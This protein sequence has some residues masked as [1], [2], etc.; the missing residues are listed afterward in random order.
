M[1]KFPIDRI[2]T[3]ILTWVAACS[4]ILGVAVKV[5]SEKTPTSFWKIGPSQDLSILDVKIDTPGRYFMVILYTI[6]STIVRTIQQEIVSPWIIQTV[7]NDKPKDDYT[8][9]YAQQIV[10]GEVLYRWFDWFMYM[11]ILLTQIDMMVIE[12]I[13]NLGTVAYTTHMYIH[14][15]QENLRLPG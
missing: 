1:K 8:K 3:G 13:G 6:I 2:T 11:H 7:Q 14:L 5:A 4:M 9:R 12:L 15:D 10:L